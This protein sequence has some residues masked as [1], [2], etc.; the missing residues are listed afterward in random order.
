MLAGCGLSDSTM[1]K[2]SAAVA[3]MLPQWA[4]GLP[5]DA[6]PRPGAPGYEDYQR[7]LRGK[8][9]IDT[10]QPAQPAATPAAVTADEPAEPQAE[11]PKPPAH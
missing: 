3:D 2:F 9:V 4:G 6:P 10:P 7:Q 5:K 11:E 8:A 1:S